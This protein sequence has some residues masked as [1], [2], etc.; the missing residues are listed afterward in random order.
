MNQDTLNALTALA[1]KLG[2]TGEHLWGVLLQQAW[3]SFWTDLVCDLAFLA[4]A[5]AMLQLSLFAYN[6]TD[7]VSFSGREGHALLCVLAG[8]GSLMSVI[9]VV[10]SIESTVTKLINPEYYALSQI[11]KSISR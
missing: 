8:L 1:E 6:H 10:C 11:L 7:V 3:V 5:Y 9:T 2:T 4:L